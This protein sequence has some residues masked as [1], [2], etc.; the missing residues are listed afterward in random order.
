MKFD[1]KTQIKTYRFWLSVSSAIFLI[2]QGV[3]KLFNI[4]ISEEVY[5]LVVN[6]IL[7]VFVFLGIISSPEE[8]K[9]KNEDEEEITKSEQVFEQNNTK[10]IKDV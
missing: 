5:A 10:N 1:L 7:G 8:A 3:L 4:T 6:A 2:L 9:D